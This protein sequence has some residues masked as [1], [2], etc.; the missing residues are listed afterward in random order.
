MNSKESR[1]IIATTII[2][3]VA[4]LSTFG[5]QI[6]GIIAEAQE[7]KDSGHKFAEDTK[8]LTTFHFRGG[9]EQI[10]FEVFN[11]DKGWHNNEPVKF[12]LLK[13]V[14]HTPLLH[15]AASHAS[16]WS[17]VPAGFDHM[18]KD[19]DVDVYIVKGTEVVQTFVYDDCNV[20]YYNVYT[21]FDKEEAWMDKGIAVID[22]YQFQCKGYKADDPNYAA[23]KNNFPK[24]QAMSSKQRVD[25]SE[26][27]ADNAKYQSAPFVPIGGN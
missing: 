12:T 5:F 3:G 21:E 1:I 10:P 15:E 13:V 2:V 27:W 22:K 8:I 7:T 18:W 17:N 23:M 6:S 11:Q 14:G 26:T 25:P 20:S 24:S 19:F 4:V 9:D 16:K